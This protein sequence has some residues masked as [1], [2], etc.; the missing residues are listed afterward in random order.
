[1]QFLKQ[2]EQDPQNGA[3]IQRGERGEVLEVTDFPLRESNTREKLSASIVNYGE[4][5]EY[6]LVWL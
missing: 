3:R 1:M 4:V 5:T 6:S 2:L